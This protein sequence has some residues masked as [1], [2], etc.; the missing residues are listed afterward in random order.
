MDS[1]KEKISK[2]ESD[3]QSET[4]PLNPWDL[5]L[6]GKLKSEVK[7]EKTPYEIWLEKKKNESGTDEIC[8]RCG[9]VNKLMP[10]VIDE[11]CNKCGY[12]FYEDGR[13]IL[14][15]M[16]EHDR[17][18]GKDSINRL[19]PESARSLRTHLLLPEQIVDDEDAEINLTF[20]STVWLFYLILSIVSLWLFMPILREI[21][22]GGI[23]VWL[24]FKFLLWLLLIFFSIGGLFR[25][26]RITSI[27]INNESAV[28]R[29]TTGT[30]TLRFDKMINIQNERQLNNAGK[31]LDMLDRCILFVWLSLSSYINE[32]SGSVLYVN[33][34][35]MSSLEQSIDFTFSG[36]E[37]QSFIK[38]M[39]VIIFMSRRKSNNCSISESAIKSA[40]KGRGDY[41]D[42]L[43]EKFDKSQ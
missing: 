1:E 16:T 7:R 39:A 17:K 38:A 42:W 14:V 3:Q 27:G 10:N 18:T 30:T 40:E 11:K 43:G 6:S 35:S 34:I 13:N 12:E 4:V 21:P 32:A 8:P 25:T 29:G 19:H 5:T 36:G 23:Y 9:A 37:Q 33:H 41:E 15:E 26:L 20:N 22:H 24:T 31:I 2:G 28:F